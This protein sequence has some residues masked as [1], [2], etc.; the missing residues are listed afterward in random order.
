MLKVYSLPNCSQCDATIKTLQTKKIEFEKVDMSKDE[1]A[2][3]R[4]KSLGYMAAP[5]VVVDN[6]N[7]WSGFR[8]DKIASL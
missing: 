3:N 2:Y 6:D 5:V 1:E 8:P 4:V 7:H